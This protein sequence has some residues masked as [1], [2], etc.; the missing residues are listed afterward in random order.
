MRTQQNVLLSK[1]NE[2]KQYLSI[3]EFD[4]SEV[5]MTDDDTNQI[6]ERLDAVLSY[7]EE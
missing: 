1:V 7:I 3:P 6:R 2:I 4:D 5:G